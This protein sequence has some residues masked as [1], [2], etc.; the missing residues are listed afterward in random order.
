MVSSSAE[1][2]ACVTEALRAREWGVPGRTQRLTSSAINAPNTMPKNR[3]STACSP[4]PGPNTRITVTPIVMAPSSPNFMSLAMRKLTRTKA[5]MPSGLTPK[6]WVRSSPKAAPIMVP[7]ICLSDSAA[8]SWKVGRIAMRAVIP[9]TVA[10]TLGIV[11][12]IL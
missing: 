11:I 1:T 8:V 12:P 10:L 7:R 6:R 3:D 5:K 4:K 9:A 2:F